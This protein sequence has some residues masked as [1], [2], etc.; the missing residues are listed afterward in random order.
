MLVA[1]ALGQVFGRPPVVVGGT[2]QQYWLSD[3][4]YA[5]DLDLCPRPSLEDEAEL[6][7]LGFRKEG[8]HWVRDDLASGFEFPGSGDDIADD[9]TVLV[10]VQGVS[11]TVIGLEDL[12]LDRLR[13]STA[14]ERAPE[15]ATMRT[16]V[17][18][19]VAWA[20]RLDAA[21]VQVRIRQ[22][23]KEEPMV[24]AAMARQQRRAA[25][26]AR[27]AL[28]VERARQLL[29]PPSPQ[30]PEGPGPGSIGV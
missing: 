22:A 1:A 9:R 5:T 23:A 25:R 21:Y 28:A 18:L 7:V 2:A 20:G 12:Y 17:G 19:A 27:R 30:E 4:Y 6:R 14:N 13:Q 3:R 8:R 15:D 29:E 10:E 26:L 11:A 16:V 24:G